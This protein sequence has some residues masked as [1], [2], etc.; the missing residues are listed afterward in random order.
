M[1]VATIW[2]FE[3]PE[4]GVE[5]LRAFEMAN[6]FLDYSRD[7]QMFL[8]TH[9]PAFYLKKTDDNSQV[10]YVTTSEQPNEGTKILT[11][12]SGTT[13][14]ESM[15]LMPLVA[16]YIEEKMKTISE[17]KRATEE[18]V[19]IDIPTIIVEGKTDKD[20]LL[21]AISIFSPEL[22]DLIEKRKLRVFTKEGQGGCKKMIDWAY[23][24]IFSGNKSKAIVL[25][26]KD[27]AG[28]IAH[29]EL[30]NSDIFSNKRSSTTIQAKYLEPSET[31]IS[32]YQKNINIPFEIE[33]L[34][35]VE[36]C[37][38]LKKKKYFVERRYSQLVKMVEKEVNRLKNVDEVFNE[39]V[40][41]KDIIDNL[42]TQ[43]P[44]VDKKGK[45]KQYIFAMD[46]EDIEKALI[47]MKNTIKMLEKVF[48]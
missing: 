1:K 9:S 23:V 25:F 33:H 34:L 31:I 36:C 17:V 43:E 32:L 38:K 27:E 46:K 12:M 20:Y 5:L 6:D 18:N 29:D 16:P 4:N 19:L 37:K 2:G 10:F 42:L 8:T 14:G 15:G 22:S 44:H 28:V 13:I 7:I 3:E 24:W 11:S 40:G 48:L 35:S 47:P 39:L 30:V 26:D 41:D 45:I 21:K